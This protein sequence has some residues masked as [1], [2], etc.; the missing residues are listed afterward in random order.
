ML[1]L[2]SAE[3]TFVGASA[4]PKL[5]FLDLS[6][7]G[8]ARLE[9]APLLSG[10][11]SESEFFVSSQFFFFKKFKFT[12]KG[13]KIRKA[14]GKS[15]LRLF[16]GHSHKTITLAGGCQLRKTAKYK[17]CLLSSSLGHARRVANTIAS[18]R[19]INEYTKRGLRQNKGG[20]VKRPGKKSTY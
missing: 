3:T 1:S 13:Y 6:L 19:P 11:S 8:S 2:G 14:G 5:E 17:L 20:C 7:H 16:F 18:I 12:G 10:R 9:S 4:S 15:S